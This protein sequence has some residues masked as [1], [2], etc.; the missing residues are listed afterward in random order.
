[1]PFPPN[2]PPVY[3]K[4]QIKIAFA[5][6]PPEAIGDFF[7]DQGRVAACAVEA[8]SP[9]PSVLLK[10]GGQNL[11]EPGYQR[12]DIFFRGIL[13]LRIEAGFRKR[14]QPLDPDHCGMFV[15]LEFVNKI[16]KLIQTQLAQ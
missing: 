8:G 2:S 13:L 5:A 9:Y 10:A 4:C 16:I 15:G 14:D 6:F 3:G 12:F 1:L 7:G 11:S